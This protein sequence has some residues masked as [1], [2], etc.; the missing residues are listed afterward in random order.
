MMRCGEND[1]LDFPALN[2][3]HH[4]GYASFTLMKAYT[5]IIPDRTNVY[6]VQTLEQIVFFKQ[7][8]MSI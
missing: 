2:K 1:Y 7:E 8:M 5:K 4:A 3:G 6:Q